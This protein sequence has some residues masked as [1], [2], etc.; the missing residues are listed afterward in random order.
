MKSP[1]EKD[2]W[3]AENLRSTWEYKTISFIVRAI[4]AMM[5]LIYIGVTA[6]TVWTWAQA[7]HARSQ[8]ADRLEILISEALKTDDFEWAHRWV[9]AR[10]KS[11]VV[12]HAAVIEKYIT[13]IPPLFISTIVRAS[14]ETETVEKT[15]FWLMY[16]QYRMR[17]DLIRCGH[18]GLIEKYGEMQAMVIHLQNTPY[19][20]AAISGDPKKT[21]MLLQEVLDFDSRYPARNKPTFVCTMMAPLVYG[22]KQDPAPEPTWATIRH[23]LRVTTE[24]EIKRMTNTT[25]AEPPAAPME[26]TP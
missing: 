10:P 21:A 3:R 11:E 23:A 13:E 17:F 15:R 4:V 6:P 18:P 9:N 22:Q 24:R 2:F 16:M 8:P 7:A 19:E 5:V 1:F 26:E 20:L 25:T 12:Q 14:R